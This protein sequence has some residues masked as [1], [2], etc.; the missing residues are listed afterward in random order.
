MND[1]SFSIVVPQGS[2]NDSFTFSM[3]GY[4][5]TSIAIKTIQT[6]GKK[7]FALQVKTTQLQKVTVFSK[8]VEKK[9]GIKNHK[10]LIH[11]TDGSTN[12][13]DIFEIAQLIKLDTVLSKIT[14]V[15]LYLSNS[16]NDSGTFRINFY[17]YD[18]N[19]PTDKL[20]EK[21]ITKTLAIKEGWLTFDLRKDMVYLK[22]NFV[23]SIEFIPAKEKTIPIYYDV[24]LGGPARSFVRT[25]SQGDWHVPPHHYRMYITALVPATKNNLKEDDAE[26]QETV[27]TAQLYS[28]YVKDTF[29]LFIHLPKNYNSK[30]KQ[31]YPVIYLLDAN[32]YFDLVVN[33]YKENRSLADAIIVGTGYKDFIQLD[34]LRQRDYTYPAALPGD[35]FP[36]SGGGDKF[37]SFIQK[38]LIPF[39]DKKYHTDTSNRTIMGHSLGAYFTL[40]ALEENTK[41]NSRVFRN[42]VAASP[43]LYYHDQYLLEEFKKEREMSRDSVDLYLTFGEREINKLNKE[44]AQNSLSFDSL[45]KVFNEKLPNIKI[46][47]QIFPNA[48]HMDTPFPTFT[49]GLYMFL[50]K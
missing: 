44:G 18:G 28:Q 23:V 11:F 14:S 48:S 46:D 2:I 22:G 6:T 19:R 3:V 31:I 17:G 47:T 24:K 32:A 34:S 36:L 37:L 12:Q 15:N 41:T 26:E 29:S 13:N 39:I 1:G 9:Y 30:G 21:N 43:S 50:K 35:S 38:E 4:S 8:L 33:A 16:R 42:Y 5:D 40:F 7:V 49:N 45:L 25:S 20:I 27:A 10:A